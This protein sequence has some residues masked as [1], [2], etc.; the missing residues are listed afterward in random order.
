MTQNG[1]Y[2]AG[3]ILTQKR[4]AFPAFPS[5]AAFFAQE[6]WRSCARLRPF[7]RKNDQRHAQDDQ[8]NEQGFHRFCKTKES[9][10]H[11]CRFTHRT[12]QHTDRPKSK[13]GHPTNP[14]LY[15][16]PDGTSATQCNFSSEQPR[17]TEEISYLCL[18]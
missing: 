18:P 8:R 5:T 11:K 10:P 17:P 7:L 15:S 6:R 3:V 4:K 2:S 12:E 16:P 13:H 14:P 1:K 9:L